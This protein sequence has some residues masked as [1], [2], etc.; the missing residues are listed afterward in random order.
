MTKQL[1]EHRSLYKAPD[2]SKDLV[3]ANTKKAPQKQGTLK[4]QMGVQTTMPIN[5]SN[6][7]LRRNTT[8]NTNTSL[9]HFQP[10]SNRGKFNFEPKLPKRTRSGQR[11]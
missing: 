3:K 11:V 5:S 4:F 10:I 6:C 9:S 7:P 1:Q 2:S 8:N